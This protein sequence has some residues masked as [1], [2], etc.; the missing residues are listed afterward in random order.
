MS[1]QEVDDPRA[2][3]GAVLAGEDLEIIVREN[4]AAVAVGEL[5]HRVA[6]LPRARMQR[7]RR[8]KKAHRF[9][10]RCGLRHV[11]HRHANMIDAMQVFSH[12]TYLLLAR[13]VAGLGSRALHLRL[14]CHQG[15]DSPQWFLNL[16]ALKDVMT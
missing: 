6:G 16:N 8:K 3:R 4:N 11:A 12:G 1:P 14:G 7:E 10:A 15:D 2:G 13:T 5:R 9:V